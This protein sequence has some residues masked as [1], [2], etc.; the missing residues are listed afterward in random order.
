MV[1]DFR[2]R[3]ALHGFLGTLMY[4]TGERR[5]GFTRTVGFES[6]PIRDHNLEKVM[7]G[8]AQRLLRL[9]PAGC[10]GG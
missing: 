6:L 1:I 10:P 8:N 7:G 5:D 4:A 3:P 2:L 9:G